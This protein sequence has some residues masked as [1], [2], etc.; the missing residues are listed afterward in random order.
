MELELG[1]IQFV[2]G[3]YFIDNE[4]MDIHEFI[5]VA[6]KYRLKDMAKN[7]SYPTA[8]L[9]IILF[10][11]TNLLVTFL[12][13][14]VLFLIT[15]FF[16]IKNFYDWHGLYESIKEDGFRPNDENGYITVK[17]TNGRYLCQNGNHRVAILNLIHDKSYKIKVWEIPIETNANKN[18]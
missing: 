12:S 16:V 10:P 2:Y 18:F 15:Y 14:L 4:N 8:L 17:L 11:L 13:I 9:A 3:Q 5:N 1:S 7:I 6:K